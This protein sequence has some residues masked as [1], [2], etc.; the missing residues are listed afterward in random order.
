L[1]TIA[2]TSNALEQKLQ[3]IHGGYI[4]R[5]KLLRGKILEAADFLAKTRVDIDVARLAGLME[6]SALRSRL[7]RLRDEVEAVSRK[8]RECQE[9]WKAVQI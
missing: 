5:S 9:E 2:L 8:E 7:E 3:K 1:E 6:E 4:S